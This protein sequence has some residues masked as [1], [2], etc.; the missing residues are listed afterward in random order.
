M[1]VNKSQTFLIILLALSIWPLPASAITVEVE[2]TALVPGCGDT[3]IGDGEQCDGIN[4]GGSSCTA[5][6]FTGGSLS[7][8]PTCSFNTSMCTATS[9][10]GSSGGGGG[11]GRSDDSDE[12]VSIP[13]TNVVFSGRAYPLSKVGILKDGQLVVTTIAGPDSIFSATI[14][15]LST[16]NYTFSV[17]GEDKN[18][19]RSSLFTFPIFITS[20]V[21]TKI[22]GIFV[23]PT[24]T[25]DKSEVKKGDNIAIFGQSTP[26]SEITINVNSEEEFFISRMSDENGT[27]L[28]NFNTAVLSLGQHS[29][30]SKGAVNG[31]ISA[32]SKL[33]EFLVGTKNVDMALP[34][35][36]TRMKG[37]VNSDF[38]VNIV[39]FSISAYWYKKVLSD[40][41]RDIE[42]EVL[43]GDGKVDLVDFSI[44]AYHWTG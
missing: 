11:S 3:F 6:G 41:F 28:L 12:F 30:K 34:S 16:G 43:S 21:T 23:A 33:V 17:Y 4:L 15:D 20:G 2:I 24:I 7:C 36:Q 14:S 32:D 26:N 19:I 5:L 29:T 40:V 39:D 25:V 37:D 8:S 1:S 42:K 10:G 38:R 27:Y 31:D 13:S 35:N 22:G 18:N 44:M 9:P